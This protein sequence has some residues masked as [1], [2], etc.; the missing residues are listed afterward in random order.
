MYCFEVAKD[1]RPVL[2]PLFFL[3]SPSFFKKLVFIRAEFL[4]DY[5][6]SFKQIYKKEAD[7]LL[8]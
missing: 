6:I 1:L 3:A 4:I 7:Q 2:V 5:F 8:F